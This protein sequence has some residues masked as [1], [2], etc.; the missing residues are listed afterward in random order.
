MKNFLQAI[1]I[2]AIGFFMLKGPGAGWLDT[3]SD[4]PR[5]ETRSSAW[6]SGTDD[7]FVSPRQDAAA[8]SLSDEA[9]MLAEFEQYYS[10]PTDCGSRSPTQQSQ[11]DSHRQ[12]TLD[13]FRSQWQ[14]YNI[15]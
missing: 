15:R 11:C 7:D 9:D 12:R 2:L 4:A 14:T 5:E 6:E 3:F 1:V 13:A 10:P 8:L